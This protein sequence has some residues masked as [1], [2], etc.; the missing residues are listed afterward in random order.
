MSLRS[1]WV[2]FVP[3]IMCE[4]AGVSAIQAMINNVV[5]MIATPSPALCCNLTAATILA[6]DALNRGSGGYRRTRSYDRLREHGT[7]TWMLEREQTTGLDSHH[8]RNVTV[9]EEGGKLRVTFSVRWKN[10]TVTM[11][12][13]PH[14][15]KCAQYQSKNGQ[16]K[17]VCDKVKGRLT[18]TMRDVGDMRPTAIMT[19][20][21]GVLY[22]PTNPN[23]SSTTEGFN[24]TALSAK[25]VYLAD[26]GITN[27]ALHKV[28]SDDI[29]KLGIDMGNTFKE[30]MK[31]ISLHLIKYLNKFVIKEL[32]DVT[33]Q[34][35][36]L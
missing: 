30:Q 11:R 31:S 5:L 12:P 33:K 25:P 6:Q 23:S 29:H 10:P 9:S 17:T 18:I 7:M 26:D 16:K 2:G 1:V 8:V 27:A 32:K 24:A 14:F 21:G 19:V 22:D 13:F 35:C 34:S 4:T 28:F 3:I 20:T 36:K 15:E